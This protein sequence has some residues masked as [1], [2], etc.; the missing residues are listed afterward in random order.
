LNNT[1]PDGETTLWEKVDE[2]LALVVDQATK[3]SEIEVGTAKKHWRK[4][5]ADATSAER[6]THNWLWRVFH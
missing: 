6:M 2:A 5:A 4:A 1:N 3:M